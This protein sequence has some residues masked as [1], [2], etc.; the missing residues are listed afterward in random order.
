[1]QRYGPV[2]AHLDGGSYNVYERSGI[3]L[4]NRSWMQYEYKGN[5]SLWKSTRTSDHT[6][7]PCAETRDQSV[8]PGLFPLYT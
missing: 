7:V 4:T 8:I 6:Y 5:D 3:H 1:M 2:L